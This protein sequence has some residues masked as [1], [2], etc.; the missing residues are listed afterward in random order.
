M[1]PLLVRV[2]TGAALFCAASVLPAAPFAHAGELPLGQ[3]DGC[4]PDW[5]PTF[6]GAPGTNNYV[7]A[8][9]VFDDG[10]PTTSP[11]GTA[12]AET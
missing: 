8:V 9:T 4:T 5:I 6:G 12:R 11:S 7:Y 1:G 2:L 10:S 3:P